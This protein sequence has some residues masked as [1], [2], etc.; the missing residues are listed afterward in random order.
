[1]SLGKKT[2]K[3]EEASLRMPTFYVTSTGDRQLDACSLETNTRAAYR[4][5]GPWRSRLPGRFLRVVLQ[6]FAVFCHD[7]N[8][9]TR[10]VRL[11]APARLRHQFGRFGRC[12]YCVFNT[13]PGSPLLM[14]Q[15]QSPGIGLSKSSIYLARSAKQLGCMR[16]TNA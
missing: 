13:G 14:P 12:Q 6:P 1:V 9:P 8:E 4:T 5:T 7:E 11:S 15:P 2:R 16:A 10:C 3:G